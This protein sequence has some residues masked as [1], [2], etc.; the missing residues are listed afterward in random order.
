MSARAL[1]RHPT[2]LSRDVFVE[3]TIGAILEL[4]IQFVRVAPQ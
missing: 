1:T 2:N 3:K 4:G